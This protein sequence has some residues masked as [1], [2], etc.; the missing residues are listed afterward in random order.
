MPLCCGSRYCCCLLQAHR[1]SLIARTGPH[2]HLQFIFVSP[3]EM[4]AVA[5]FIRQRGR[6]AISELAAK[7]NQVGGDWPAKRAAC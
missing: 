7:S 2:S 3:E 4:E 6:I 1:T 5:D